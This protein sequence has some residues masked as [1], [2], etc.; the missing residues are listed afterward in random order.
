[1]NRHAIII[2]FAG[3]LSVAH[4]QIEVGLDMKRTTFIRG[5]PMEATVIVRNLAGKDIMLADAEGDRWFGFQILKGED[6]PIAPFS[7]E[8][9]NPPQVLLNGGTMRRTVDLVRLYPV[10]EYG[11]YSVRAAIY[12]HETGKY[13]ASP[14]VKIEVSEGRKLWSQTVGVPATKEGSGDYHVM[15]LL[16]FPHPKELVLYLR[17]E[18][19]KI[20]TV[21][22]TYPLGRFLGGGEPSHEFDRENTLH[23]LHFVGPGQY[24]LSKVG[25]NGEWYGQTTWQSG[26]GRP[27]VRR[28]EDGRMVVV[29]ASRSSEKPPPGPEVPRLSDRPA[30]LPK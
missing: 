22:G 2:L 27:F 23:I 26:K 6:N 19:A 18:D 11:S 16:T 4:A 1:M 12:F 9:K 30:I 15:S 10:N 7:G 24:F 28:K 8:Y 20:G 5:E 14:A 17:V 13:V 29:G 25:V 21:F 3:L